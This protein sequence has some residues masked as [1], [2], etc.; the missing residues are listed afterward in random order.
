MLAT[1]EM[2]S[3]R[4]FIEAA[5]ARV[6][7]E[8]AWE[9]K[10]D[11]EIGKNKKTGD[12]IVKVDPQYYRPTEVELLIGDASK[13]AD[14]LGWKSSTPFTELVSEMVEADIELM[15]KNPMA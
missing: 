11:T 4:D 6:D 1:G 2:H 7:I 9:G 12:T 3:V 10:G 15:K 8:V 13:A 14:K 5:F